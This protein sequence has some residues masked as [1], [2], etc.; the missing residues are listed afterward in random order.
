MRREFKGRFT[1]AGQICLAA[2]RFILTE[3]I[4][5]AFEE[6]F[7]E[8]AQTIKVG[9]PTNEATQMGPVARTDL[10]DTL[11]KQVQDSVS[12]GAVLLCGGKPVPGKG[13]F[14]TPTVLSQVKPGMRAFDEET[15]GPV[16]AIM[17]APDAGAAVKAANA[18]EFGLSGNIWTRNVELARRMAR[19]MYTGGVFINGVSASD[20][21]VPVGGVKKSGYGRELSSFGPHAFVNAQ[22]VWIQN[23]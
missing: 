4:A 10:R 17:R 13:A 15:F 21:R 23:S 7:V 18:S 20:P 22:T 6:Q 16:A 1:N 5:D 14:Y 2:K 3:N 11:H 9:D 12:A 8:A 19:E